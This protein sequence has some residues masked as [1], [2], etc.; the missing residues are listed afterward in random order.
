M[1]LDIDVEFPEFEILFQPIVDIN[2]GSIHYFEALA[3]FQSVCGKES[4][5]DRIT[6]AEKVGLIGDFDLAMIRRVL[7]WL[8][9]APAVDGAPRIAVNISGQSLGSAEW[10]AALCALLHDNPWSRGRLMFEITETAHLGNLVA[11]N[12]F[13]QRLRRLGYPVCL[14]DF[15]AGAANFEYLSSLEVD[16]VKLD[17]AA[18][19]GGRAA[20]KGGAFL[21]ALVGVCRDLGVATV[22][23]MIEDEATL[24]F[25]RDCGVRYVQGYLFGKP[26]ADIGAFHHAIP[27]SLFPAG[28]VGPGI[29]RT[30][31]GHAVRPPGAMAGSGSDHAGG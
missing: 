5:Y 16:V 3:R 6:S 30:A 18:V 19:Q 22:A 21:K 12:A 27:A 10:V 15:G 4:P 7:G 26:S 11:A 2:L 31:A 20:R 28:G 1:T 9:T 13:V 8:P 23:E 24:V 25:V 29:R 14:D 17:G